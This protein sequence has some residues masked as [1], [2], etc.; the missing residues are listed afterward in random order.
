[1]SIIW[2]FGNRRVARFILAE[3]FSVVRSFNFNTRTIKFGSYSKKKKPLKKLINFVIKNFIFFC[4]NMVL[5]HLQDGL[6]S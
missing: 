5:S 2:L 4:F 6:F 1:M 3:I